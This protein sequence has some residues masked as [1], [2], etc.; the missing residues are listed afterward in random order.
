MSDL[1]KYWKKNKRQIEM[2]ITHLNRFQIRAVRKETKISELSL[3]NIFSKIIH[4]LWISLLEIEY[5][6]L[7]SESTHFTNDFLENHNTVD[8]SLID[9]WLLLADFFFKKQ[10]LK[11]QDRELNKLNLGMTTYSRYQTIKSIINDDIRPFVE[12]R[13]KL[14]HGQWAVAINLTGK[15]KNQELTTNIWKLSKKEI[16]LIKAFVKHLP[17]L[18]KLLITSK[19]TFER[20]YDKYTHKILK[21]KSDL[22]LKFEWLK[23]KGGKRQPT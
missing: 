14:V 12:L 2:T 19:K 20:D 21:A 23:K 16:M 17:P 8:A 7:I 5:N 6:I 9:K 18:M 13:N 1:V 3:D 22:E 15:G 11:R 10:Y 4:P